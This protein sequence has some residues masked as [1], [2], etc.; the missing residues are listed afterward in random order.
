MT[1]ISDSDVQF[2]QLGKQDALRAQQL[3]DVSDLIYTTDDYIY[4]AMFSEKKD[5]LLM[6]PEM[7]RMRD[8]MFRTEHLFAAFIGDR[9]AA[10]ILWKRGAMSWTSAVYENAAQRL[11]IVPSQYL[12]RV[13]TE[14]FASYSET[15]ADT[16]AIINVSVSAQLRGAGLGRRMLSAFLRK[17]EDLCS[18]YE[19][20]VLAD[21]QPAYKLYTGA[22]FQVTET[23]QGFSIE[24]RDLPCY[25]ML[26]RGAG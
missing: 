3:R 1:S 13:K 7:F 10:L 5:A 19:L 17:T 11:G 2:R 20:F 24:S 12:D 14:Y 21:N 22:G 23:L 16:V 8:E 26:R 4:P 9:I 15:G 25:R 18:Q 6:I